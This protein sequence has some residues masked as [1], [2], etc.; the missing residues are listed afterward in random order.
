MAAVYQ[1][2]IADFCIVCASSTAR[3]V[4]G[5]QNRTANLAA[6]NGGRVRAAGVVAARNAARIVASRHA[7]IQLGFIFQ[8]DRAAVHACDTARAVIRLHRVIKAAVCG[9]SNHRIRQVDARDTANQAAAARR[10]VGLHRGIFNVSVVDA[11]NTTQILVAA[12]LAAQGGI[13]LTVCNYAVVPAGNAARHALM[14]NRTVVFAV[15]QRCIF[16]RIADDAARKVGAVGQRPAIAGVGLRQGKTTG[17]RNFNRTQADT[18]AQGAV[19]VV[20][21]HTARRG[22]VVL[23]A[24][25]GV[26]D[27]QLC[28]AVVVADNAAHIGVGADI[29]LVGK[30]S[31]FDRVLRVIDQAAVS[32]N[33]QLAAVIINRGKYTLRNL[34]RG[35]RQQAVIADDA[36]RKALR[37]HA[38]VCG[39]C[40][41][42]AGSCSIAACDGKRIRTRRHRHI[43]TNHTTNAE[44]TVYQ[45]CFYINLGQIGCHVQAHHAA[46]RLATDIHCRAVRAGLRHSLAN[47]LT[48]DG[49]SVGIFVGDFCRSIVIASHTADIVFAVQHGAHRHSRCRTVPCED[50]I[51]TIAADQTTYKVRVDGFFFA[52]YHVGA[53]IFQQGNAAAVGRIVRC[54]AVGAVFNCSRSCCGSAGC[55]PRGIIQARNTAHIG[56]ILPKARHK[57]GVLHAADGAAC[58]VD[59]HNT[60]H[61]AV[62]EHIACVCAAGDFQTAA[63]KAA[64]NAAHKG[65]AQHIALLHAA[66]R[67]RNIFAKANQ[68]AHKVTLQRAG[69]LDDAVCVVALLDLACQRCAGQVAA[70]TA[71]AAGQ[72]DILGV[73]CQAAEELPQ[74]TATALRAALIVSARADR[75]GVG[76]TGHRCRLCCA[77]VNISCNTAHKAVACDSS[78]VFDGSICV[79]LACRYQTC[80]VQCAEHAA[81]ADT[82]P[83]GFGCCA[84]FRSGGCVA[85]FVI[86][87][88]VV[89]SG[90]CL[91]LQQ[92]GYGDIAGNLQIGCRDTGAGLIFGYG[93]AHEAANAARLVCIVGIFFVIY[94]FFSFF[95][96]S[97][98]G[99]FVKGQHSQHL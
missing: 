24:I 47:D 53:Q 26:G 83:D 55:A 48:C 81:H 49:Q 8:R 82:A 21:A 27:D 78:C 38:A 68:A 94:L 14:C 70:G 30:T 58:A 74:H 29:Q 40:G 42:I 25:C 44:L 6:H 96:R 56:S 45:R 99:R 34:C 23:R 16:G 18:P 86:H 85:G 77:V 64:R 66:V 7:D 65:T 22:R 20:F 71:G 15:V 89:C 31:K 36:A 19:I 51:C 69:F 52:G 75:A 54:H 59:R 9:I 88:S 72:F 93:N 35:R 73:A 13:G 5:C 90:G 4:A 41:K 12:L 63:G 39:L 10:C 92:T 3:V 17:I 11:R 60:A 46:D 61:I 76:K 98:C 2:Y 32:R 62:A 79:G 91:I 37:L 1:L 80:R 67:Q 97:Y 50:S 28:F 43:G 87:R 84:G 95:T 33:L 57:A